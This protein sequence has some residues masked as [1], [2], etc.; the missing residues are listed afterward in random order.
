MKHEYS[1]LCYSSKKRLHHCWSNRR[2]KGWKGNSRKL[3]NEQNRF[4]DRSC[5]NPMPVVMTKLRITQNFM[6]GKWIYD[7]VW[8]DHFY[9]FMEIA[10]PIYTPEGQKAH[11]KG[12]HKNLFQVSLESVSFLW[13]SPLIQL[14]TC[15][16]YADVLPAS[17]IQPIW[18][19][20]H[21]AWHRP[22]TRSRRSTHNLSSWQ[23]ATPLCI[24]WVVSFAKTMMFSSFLLFSFVFV[25][26]AD[27]AE[28][29]IFFSPTYEHKKRLLVF[30]VSSIN[31]GEKLNG[32]LLTNSFCFL[33]YPQCLSWEGSWCC[34]G[35]VSALIN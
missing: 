11:E 10:A 17:K 13:S 26:S 35:H 21:A 5:L 28:G 20:P 9:C 14:L 19:P 8:W 4:V 27:S 7:M 3:E 16:W 23:L 15:L 29:E 22:V 34:P 31:P 6:A 24:M 18:F 32:W 30:S 1:S 2:C 33:P 12:Y 25:I